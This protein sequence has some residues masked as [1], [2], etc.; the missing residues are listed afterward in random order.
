MALLHRNN[1][2]K[3]AAVINAILLTIPLFYFVYII[4]FPVIYFLLIF[5]TSNDGLMFFWAYWVFE[6]GIIY[7]ITKLL[8]KGFSK[9]PKNFI[10]FITAAALIIFA[11]FG[12]NTFPDHTHFP[13]QTVTDIVNDEVKDIND[14]INNSTNGHF[15]PASYYIDKAKIEKR[16]N[17]YLDTMTRRDYSSDEYNFNEEFFGHYEKEYLDSISK[18]MVDTIVY[19]SSLLK[20]YIGIIYKTKSDQYYGQ[21]FIGYKKDSASYWKLYSSQYSTSTYPDSLAGCKRDLREIYFLNI[22][23]IYAADSLGMFSPLDK[24]FWTA[25]YF[26]KGPDIDSL[27]FFQTMNN[28]QTQKRTIIVPYLPIN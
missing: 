10:L 26:I 1:K 13:S 28:F 25:R 24:Q 20:C 15:V 19:D 27:Y 21:G 22:R 23:Q 17:I 8:I 2:I 7:F 3:L 12:I 18:I 9:I 4:L 11:V 6:I 5:I 16:F 14:A